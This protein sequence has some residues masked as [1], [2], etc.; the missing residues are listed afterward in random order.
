[1]LQTPVFA[2]G[3]LAT[4]EGTVA[5]AIGSGRRAAV[6]VHNALSGEHLVISERA[7]ARRDVDEWCDEVM[8]SGAMKLHLFERH[9][10][11]HGAALP[12]AQRRSTFD[13]IHSG[14]PDSHEA[15]RCLSCGVCN[16]CG[17]CTTYC[18]EGVLKRIG[19]EFVFDYSFC[20]GCGVCVA[21]CPRSV[22]LM[23]HL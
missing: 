12:P 19:H 20:K 22:I 2:I 23:S 10:A 14:L 7:E 8:R 6:Q 1:M 13:E 17:L 11:K 5:A 16:E 4:H 9:P 18:P 21:E 15:A 3:D